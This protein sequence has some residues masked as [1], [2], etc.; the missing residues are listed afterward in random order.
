MNPKEEIAIAIELADASSVWGLC[1]IVSNVRQMR[2]ALESALKEIERL[3][4]EGTQSPHRVAKDLHE[5]IVAGLRDPVL[6]E[7]EECDLDTTRLL[8]AEAER[9]YRDYLFDARGDCATCSEGGALEK[10]P[11]GECE[12]SKRI[13]GHHCNCIWTQDVCCW[14]GVENKLE[15]TWAT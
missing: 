6:L 11:Y 2:N 10:C 8:I 1:C 5:R 3:Q 14:C 9:Q 4:H 13:C 7:G 15:E 12:K